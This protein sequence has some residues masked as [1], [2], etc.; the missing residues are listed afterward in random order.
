[1][2]IAF[3]YPFASTP[4][5]KSIKWLPLGVATLIANIQN[6]FTN[7]NFQIY[8][9]KEEINNTILKN[10]KN[11][12]KNLI[13]YFTKE[14]GQSLVKKIDLEKYNYLFEKITKQLNLKKYDHYFN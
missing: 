6:D 5:G 13:D 10:H 7:I 3:L 14:Y 4:P 2:N 1:M 8:D 12:F 11:N 9:I